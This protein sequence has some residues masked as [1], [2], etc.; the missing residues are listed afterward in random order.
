MV[1][2]D[3][4]QFADFQVNVLNRLEALGEQNEEIRGRLI[5]MKTVLFGANGEPGKLTII[6]KRLDNH[7]KSIDRI[8]NALWPMIGAIVLLG[9]IGIEG[10]RLIF[11]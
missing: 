8:K 11:K 7:R 3:A 5:Q 2:I 6:D 4:K 10:L 9:W 1:E